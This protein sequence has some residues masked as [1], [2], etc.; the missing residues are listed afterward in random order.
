MT[1]IQTHLDGL[2]AW[3]ISKELLVRNKLATTRPQDLADVE[4]IDGKK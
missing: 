3:V 2:P 1:R 4:W